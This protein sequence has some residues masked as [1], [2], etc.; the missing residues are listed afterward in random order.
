MPKRT[1]RLLFGTQ[2]KAKS[3]HMRAVLSPLPIQIITPHDLK[4]DL[5]VPETGNTPTENA[6]LKAQA[7]FQASNV[8]T[9]SIDVGL[10]IDKFPPNK[11]PGVY[12][13]RVQGKEK[14]DEE[15]IAYYTEELQKVG[16]TSTATWHMGIALATKSGVASTDYQRPTTLTAKVSHAR[17]PGAPL[18]ALQIDPKTGKYLSE[19]TWEERT[20]LQMKG[21][22]EVRAFIQTH[23]LPTS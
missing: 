5:D 7:Y 16:G 11:Q 19:L 14:D 22:D 3:D 18:S 20:A 10:H 21:D 4:I 15:M 6:E 13:R 2:N 17:I 8:P 1:K 9:F 12:V 23:F